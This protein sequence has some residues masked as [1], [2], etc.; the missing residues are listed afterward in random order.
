[1][2]ELPILNGKVRYFLLEICSEFFVIFVYYVKISVLDLTNAELKIKKAY[3]H[4]ILSVLNA[5]GSGNSI[6]KGMISIS[7]EK[8]LI[9]N[10]FKRNSNNKLCIVFAII[11]LYIYIFINFIF[12]FYILYL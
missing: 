8:K 9:Y 5:L 11:Y 10:F 12:I 7:L 6:K 3:C 1:L 4:D 2:A